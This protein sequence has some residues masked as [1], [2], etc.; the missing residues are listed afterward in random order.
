MDF[1]LAEIDRKKKQLDQNEV[2]SNKKYFKRGDLAAKQAED[3]KRKLEEQEK[4]KKD[5]IEQ[6]STELFLPAKKRKEGCEK[7]NLIPREE[8]IR[9][10]RERNEPIRLFGELDE[11]ACQRLRRIEMLAP[12]INKGLRNDFKAAM[13]KIDQEYLAQLVNQ[14][15]GEVQAALLEE[16]KGDGTTLEDI[17]TLAKG[18]EQGDESLDQE[19]TYKFLQFLLRV[20]GQDLDSK[21]VEIK[22]SLE[23]KLAK[24]THN[25]THSY[26]RPLL[27]KLK[28]K[29]TPRDIR[30]SLTCII[31]NLLDREYVKANDSYLQM[32]IGNAP[33][34]IG[35]TMVGIHART[36]REKI[37]AQNVAHVL[38]DETQRKYIQGLKRL[39]TF[40]Q[41]KFPA[42]P[43]KSVDYSKEKD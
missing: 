13:E 26:L 21:P 11:E 24:A 42:D 27:R 14:Q 36:G 10:L 31:K 33:W 1:L 35:V 39:M 38:N 19:V 40:C 2:T 23:G 37:F 4:K 12:E 22:R 29:N 16:M 43:S 8:V 17:K 20:W 7:V 32:A 6:Q 9:R 15:G 18:M 34:P 28:T 41:K 5:E 30:S 3:K 25:Q